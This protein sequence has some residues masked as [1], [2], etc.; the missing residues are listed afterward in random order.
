[1]VQPLLD[2]FAF[3]TSVKWKPPANASGALNAF[4]GGGELSSPRISR[5]LGRPTDL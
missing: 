1:M 4:V 5:S 3:L 2:W